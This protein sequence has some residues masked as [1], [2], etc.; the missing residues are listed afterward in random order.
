MALMRHFRKKRPALRVLLMTGYAEVHD[1]EEVDISD[2]IRKP[3]DVATLTGRI[4]QILR[5]P[6]LRAIRGGAPDAV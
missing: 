5:R 4:E 2:I 3:F 6:M 1:G